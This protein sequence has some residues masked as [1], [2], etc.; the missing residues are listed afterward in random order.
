MFRLFRTQNNLSSQIK[1]LV[2]FKPGRI[3]LYELALVPKS[4]A[5][6]IPGHIGSNNE[7]LEYLGDAILSAIITEYLF[8]TFP[9]DNEGFLTKIRSKFVKGENLNQLGQKIGLNKLI[10]PP[11]LV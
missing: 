3:Q 5:P 1:K 6:S 9:N 7:R 2:G 11:L 4:A 8:K 10:S